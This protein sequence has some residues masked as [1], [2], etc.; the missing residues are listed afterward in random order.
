MSK[1]GSTTIDDHSL[2]RQLEVAELYGFSPPYIELTNAK[3]RFEKKIKKN[4]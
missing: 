1:Y 3:L 2:S 4:E